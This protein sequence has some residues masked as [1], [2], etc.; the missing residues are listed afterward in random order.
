MTAKYGQLF[1]KD[2]NGTVTEVVTPGNVNDALLVH[3]TGDETIGGAKT[4]TGTTTLSGTAK[5]TS[6][7]VV[8]GTVPNLNF[9]GSDLVRDSNPGSNRYLYP[10]KFLDKN[11]DFL[12]FLEFL[13]GSGGNRRVGI[14]VYK[15]DGTVTQL[16]LGFDTGGTP[17]IAWD[18]KTIIN[19][20]DNQTVGGAKTFSGITSFSNDINQ[21]NNIVLSGGDFVRRT[22]DDGWIRLS[23]ASKANNGAT[24]LM[25][26]QDSASTPG[27][28]YLTARDAAH[29]RK[30]LYGTPDGTL[31]W[32]GKGFVYDSGDQSIEGIKTFAAAR[33]AVNVKIKSKGI[34]Y[35]TKPSSTQADGVLKFVSNDDYETGVIDIVRY[36]GGA[37]YMQFLA[38]CYN[39]TSPQGFRICANGTASTATWSVAPSATNSITLGENG[40]RWKEIW[41]NQS[42]LNTSSD[43]RIKQQIANVPDAV[44][45]AWGDINWIQ[46]KYN[47][48]VA[49]K[50]ADNARIHNGLIAQRVDEVFKDHGL[51]VSKYGLFL[52]DE[53]EAEPEQKDENG[54]VSVQ[55]KE[56]G[57]AYGLRYT[58]A[59]CMEAAYQRRR[60]DRMEQELRELKAEIAAIKEQI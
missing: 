25:Y 26:G 54:N 33:G 10:I 14:A 28:F 29:G 43:E 30:D 19:G 34:T 45:D 12:G 58:E 3:K 51:D 49:E 4:F 2:A 31:T 6:T 22:I 47:D 46:Y 16:R 21:T 52:Y 1:V 23:A 44:L 5:F 11:G 50:G 40:S 27:A 57:N 18:D 60:A 36:S 39:G 8:Y 56:A 41:C 24:L 38:Y 32:A 15:Q 53:W 37:Q 9:Q 42:S 7:P 17:Y 48:S 55:A 59:L 35:N 20:S 13:V